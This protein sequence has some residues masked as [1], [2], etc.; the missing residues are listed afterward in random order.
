MNEKMS[1]PGQRV[2]DD[3]EDIELVGTKIE[4]ADDAD[5]REEDGLLRNTR[6][7]KRS[8]IHNTCRICM[9]IVATSVF[10]FMLIQLWS[11]YGDTIKQRVFSPQVVGAGRFDGEDHGKLFGMQ[12]H[13]WENETLHLNMTKPEYNLVQVDFESPQKWSHEWEE[14][15]LKITMDIVDV[16]TVMVWS[17]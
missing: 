3:D 5:I 14:D 2:P 15:C 16:V 1:H 10:T 13:K 11:N 6:V 12:F 9:G 17:I 7:K 8:C 4:M